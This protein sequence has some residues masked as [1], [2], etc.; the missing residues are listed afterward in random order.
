MLV[1]VKGRGVLVISAL[2]RFGVSL[3]SLSLV[4]SM[5]MTGPRSRS[6]ALSCM[7]V[8]LPVDVVLRCGD[9][10]SRA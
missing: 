10:R 6:C 8:L 7:L 5:L 9:R 4:I 1:K 3:S 2:L